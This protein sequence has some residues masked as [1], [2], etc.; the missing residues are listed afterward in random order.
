M[1]MD[2]E[3]DRENRRDELDRAGEDEN[4]GKR[5]DGVQRC[6]RD[7]AAMA[8]DGIGLRIAP[9]EEEIGDEVLGLQKR[10]RPEE[11]NEFRIH[12]FEISG[13]TLWTSVWSSFS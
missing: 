1:I 10:Q 2:V 5:E 11:G 12:A 8:I 6:M 4:G 9:P 3:L 13:A 7:A